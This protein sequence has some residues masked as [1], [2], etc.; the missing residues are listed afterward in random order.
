[1]ENLCESAVSDY[2]GCNASS[3]I[4]AGY[5]ALNSPRSAVPMVIVVR[6]AGAR[7]PPRGSAVGLHG[8]MH[9]QRQAPSSPPETRRTVT[10]TLTSRAM[11][12]MRF[13][14]KGEQWHVPPAGRG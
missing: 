13:F 2:C 10:G 7:R 4:I 1:M 3:A 11:R 5:L 14:T 9:E 6:L 8:L 12:R